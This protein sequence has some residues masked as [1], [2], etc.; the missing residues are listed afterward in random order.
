MNIIHGKVH[1]TIGRQ[2]QNVPYK[3]GINVLGK[4]KIKTTGV[5]LNTAT[6]ISE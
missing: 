4:E 2:T 6:L 3:V 1:S 5:L